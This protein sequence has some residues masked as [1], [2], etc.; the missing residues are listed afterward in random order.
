MAIRVFLFDCGGVLLRDGDVRPYDTWAARLSLTAADL[1]ARLWQGEAWKAA[2]LGLIT[3]GEFWERAGRDLGLTHREDVDALRESLSS[4]L[5]VDPQVLSLIDRVRQDHR[6]AMLSNATD[7]L[8]SILADRYGVA[9]RFE[10]IL[11]SA[12]IGLAKPDPAIYQHALGTLGVPATE[13]VFV[14]DRAE[15]VAAAAG[16]GLHVAWFIGASELERQL[17]PFLREPLI[18]PS[19]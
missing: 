16:L 17:A 9:D 12:R 3:D 18:S 4:T 19:M 2:E 11:N 15:N 7:A 6:V 8:E 14:D 5:Q 10:V 13:A 1:R